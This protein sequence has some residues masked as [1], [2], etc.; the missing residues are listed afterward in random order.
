MWDSC[1]DRVANHILEMMLVNN[2]L[3]M[4]VVQMQTHLGTV[5]GTGTEATENSP[6]G[7]DRNPT[8]TTTGVFSLQRTP[9]VASRTIATPLS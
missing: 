8:D 9:W 3:T 1:L 4:R 5:F 7:R 2:R 6:H